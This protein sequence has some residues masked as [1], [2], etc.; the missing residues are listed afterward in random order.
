[1]MLPIRGI[2]E[3]FTGGDESRPAVELQAAAAM[4]ASRF[5]VDSGRVGL[6]RVR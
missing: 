6:N 4:A 5:W 1:M 2:E 3:G